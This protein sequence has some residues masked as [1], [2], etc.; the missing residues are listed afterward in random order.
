MQ[1]V[2][3]RSQTASRDPRRVGVGFAEALLAVLAVSW[4]VG[5]HWGVDPAVRALLWLG[6]VGVSTWVA[7]RWMRRGLRRLLWRLRNRLIIAYLLIAVVPVGLIMLLAALA[8]WVLLGQIAIYLVQLRLEERASLLQRGAQ[9]LLEAGPE[10]RHKAWLRLRPILEDSLPGVEAIVMEG[11]RVEW[12]SEPELEPPP[13]GWGA[14]RGLVRRKGATW[15]WGRAVQSDRSATLVVRLSSQ[16]W[17]AVAHGLGPISLM[18][19]SE[20]TKADMPA[21]SFGP[22]TLM[23]TPPAHSRFDWEFSWAMPTSVARWETPGKFDSP[24][25]TVHT[26][27]S[28]VL[29][30]LF[31]QRAEGYLVL[32]LLYIVAAAFLGVEIIALVVGVS[33]SRTITRAAHAIYEAT[34]RV[35]GGDL[36]YRIEVR[37]YDQLAEIARSF[38]HMTEQLA[39]LLAV[40]QEK[41]R[42]QADLEIAS[43]VQQRLYPRNLP[44]LPSLELH[45]LC[46]P[47]R[48]VSGDYYDFQ[49]LGSDRLLVV[50]GDVVG[51]GISAALL[52]A[53]LQAALRARLG[54]LEQWSQVSPERLVSELNEQLHRD[55]AAEKYATVFLAVY[56][57][58]SGELTYTNAGHPAPVLVREGALERLEANGTVVGAFEGGVYEQAKVWLGPGDVL[59]CY[60]DGVTELENEYGDM[61]GEQRLVD[62]V[63]RF[64]K[65]PLADI[66]EAILQAARDWSAGQDFSDDLT[67]VL[68]R[69]KPDAAVA[70]RESW[71]LA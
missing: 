1:A 2:D 24:L 62:V 44:H 58:A 52:M 64:R 68:L 70:T 38:N 5:G 53:T 40:A 15:L 45:A 65:R 30:A 37:G 71:L 32:R 51:K 31:R 25:L 60:S 4:W 54:T 16:L 20:T 13:A 46:Q 19:F 63:V 11:T 48:V 8:G 47:A 22:K 61:F 35:R 33:L 26:R 18:E 49:L 21:A 43:E 27:I 14:T 28:A 9:A 36:S 29:A 10:E 23:R 67:L 17:D 66:A 50:V 55:T 12:S 6:L 57:D 39:R 41:Q 7:L 56:D 34:Q 59:V 42:M 3:E 69:R